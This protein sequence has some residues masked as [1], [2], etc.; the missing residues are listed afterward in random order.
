MKTKIATTE[1]SSIGEKLNTVTMN[2][3]E[4][5]KN[6]IDLETSSHSFSWGNMR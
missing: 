5:P 4:I 2:I 6:V 3:G 1:K